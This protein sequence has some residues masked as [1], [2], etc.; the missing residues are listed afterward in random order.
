MSKFIKNSVALPVLGVAALLSLSSV[1]ASAG[2]A[3]HFYVK[4]EVGG[5]FASSQK[6]KYTQDNDKDKAVECKPKSIMGIKG[7]VSFGYNV[8][9][10]IRAELA[11][12]HLLGAKF[13]QDDKSSIPGKVALSNTTLLLNSYYS[14]PTSSALSPYITLGLGVHIPG[15]SVTERPD[16]VK[17]KVKDVSTEMSWDNLGFAYRLG[18]GLS[19]QVTEGMNLDL[20]YTAAN[21]GKVTLEDK[22]QKMTFESMKGESWLDLNHSVTLGARFSF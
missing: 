21:L 19:L 11:I 7:G 17:E 4:A 22:D 8:N 15:I 1:V 10:D 12:S 14:F 3:D 9:D 6:L 18:A 20:Q 13:E 5:Q 2:E 16:K